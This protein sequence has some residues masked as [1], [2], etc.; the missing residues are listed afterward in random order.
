MA[1]AGLCDE[2][3]AQSG[4]RLIGAEYPLA[5]QRTYVTLVADH[6]NPGEVIFCADHERYEYEPTAIHAYKQGMAAALLRSDDTGI[7][8]MYI[9]FAESGL[10]A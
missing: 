5:S 2:D 7:P 8:A 9:D 4:D 6:S 3:I 10:L 1:R